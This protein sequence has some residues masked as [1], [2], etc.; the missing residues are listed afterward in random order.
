MKLINKSG[1][2]VGV[3]AERAEELLKEGFEVY[4]EPVKTRKQTTKRKKNTNT[5]SSPE[6]KKRRVRSSK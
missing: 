3:S 5:S 2:V 6:R 4:T 1:V